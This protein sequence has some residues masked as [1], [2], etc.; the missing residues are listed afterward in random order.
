VILFFNVTCGNQIL[1]CKDGRDVER[2]LFKREIK[3]LRR[4]VIAADFAGDATR[5]FFE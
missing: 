1:L 3:R 5:F 4:G 2:V